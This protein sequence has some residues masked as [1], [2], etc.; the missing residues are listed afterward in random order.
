MVKPIADN[1]PC[2]RSDA[3]PRL[4]DLVRFL[5]PS[6]LDP[7]EVLEHHFGLSRSMIRSHARERNR[8]ACSTNQRVGRPPGFSNATHDR[9]SAGLAAAPQLAELTSAEQQRLLASW[10]SYLRFE[11]HLPPELTAARRS[12]LSCAL[13]E[14]ALR[15][16]H[17][18]EAGD[19]KGVLFRADAIDGEITSSDDTAIRVPYNRFQ[20]DLQTLATHVFLATPALPLALFPIS[21][22]IEILIARGHAETSLVVVSTVQR[23]VQLH[24]ALLGGKV[25]ATAVF[26]MAPTQNV[27]RVIS[28]SSRRS[29]FS[30]LA[31][32]EQKEVLDLNLVSERHSRSF[33]Q[34]MSMMLTAH[35]D[36]TGG[37]CV[38][39]QL[40]KG[41][42]QRALMVANSWARDSFSGKAYF[43][44]AREA[45]SDWR[46]PRTS[47]HLSVREL[48]SALAQPYHRHATFVD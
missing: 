39:D 27:L 25:R 10:R 9:I 35:N 46:S 34:S 43:D 32:L 36:G 18:R 31:L 42:S 30:W 15:S 37:L 21:V 26:A 33:E 41:R 48:D 11:S 22:I 6:A 13:A 4:C 2:T 14:Y 12:S 28:A 1:I 24:T 16:V 45:F 5:S 8:G 44:S 3:Y 20:G 19:S 17:V 38:A 47:Q 29:L 40:V 7:Y 23:C